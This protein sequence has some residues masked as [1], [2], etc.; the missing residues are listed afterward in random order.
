KVTNSLTGTGV[1]GVAVSTDPVVTGVNMTTDAQ[2][3][4]AGQLPAGVY[5]L[6]YKGT[7]LTTATATASLT[8]GQTVTKNVAMVPVAPVVITTKVTGTA[9]PGQTVAV[10]VTVTPMDGSTPGAVTWTQKNGVPVTP[11]GGPSTIQV[12]LPNV[13]AFKDEF[14]TLLA[15][16]TDL[17]GNERSAILNRTMVMGIAPLDLEEASTV[18]LTASVPSGGKTYTQDVPIVVT[19]PFVWSTGLR[20]QAVGL[21]VLLH[22]KTGASYNWTL[23][24]PSGSQASVQDATT[25]NPYFTPDITGKYTLTETVGNATI[26]I[27]AGK[28]VGAIDASGKPS[29]NCTVCHS[30]GPSPIAPDKFTPWMASGHA[31]I[32]TQNLNAGGHYSSACFPC[33]TVGYD[34][35]ATGNPANNGFNDQPNYSNFLTDY[36]DNKPPTSS[37][38]S[39]VANPNNWANVLANY[40]AVA[41]LAN[42]QCENCH[43]PQSTPAHPSL[44][45]VS[46]RVSISS[47]VCGRCHGEPARHGRFQQWQES[48]HGNYELA[49]DE[50]TVE[51][52]GATAGHCG[53]CHAGQGFLKWITQGDLTKQIQGANGNATVAELTALGLTKDTVHPQTCTVCHDPHA[54]G[55]T[56]GEPNTATV[57]I[58]DDTPLLPAGY[59]ALGV[60]RGAICITCH[61]TRNGAHNDDVG[62]P[63]NYS[64]PHVAS[65]GDVLMGQ[66]AYYGEI[67]ERSKHSFI[68]DT[69]ATCHMELTP[70]PPEFSFS[71][72]GTNHSFVAS[73]TICTQC[74]GAFDG[75]TLQESTE[76]ELEALADVMSEYLMAKITAAG[77]IYIKDY[78]PHTF[79]GANV[80]VKSGIV[81][82]PVSN[83]SGVAPV[84]VHGQQSYVVKFN[85]PVSFT[86]SA[87]DTQTLS[88]AQVQLGDF[89]TDAAGTVKLI[90]A[91]DAT[92]PESK[93]DPLIKAGWNYFL[94]H[95][96]SSKGVHNPSFVH[97]ALSGAQAA[98]QQALEVEI[99]PV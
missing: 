67:A 63:T 25:Q 68:A 24:A 36:F 44:D 21:P 47:D 39:P 40:P 99:P 38:G 17:D 30:P 34:D 75:G 98:L 93:A 79:N 11:T 59:A 3:N 18:T 74:H 91:K 82:V 84:E 26:D 80:D 5:A 1:Q 69:C 32:F 42:I 60:G 71:G 8:A 58:T 72:A 20:T 86:Y 46:A 64:A 48:G 95:G 45:L 65:Q 77:T 88:Q 19:L 31:E 49:I 6:T 56:S 14:L 27:Y 87:S 55:N 23:T 28:W 54:Q 9:A 94:I 43:G 12:A 73:L 50:A 53:R 61:N 57:R 70:P 83:I 7:N 13:T 37:G 97:E 51:N 92:K 2:G 29:S 22:T 33:H 62:D 76:A 35:T 15:E 96:D 81:G 10:S 66:N 85:T 16:K 89:T 41:Q 78:T 4:Y 90:L 52:R